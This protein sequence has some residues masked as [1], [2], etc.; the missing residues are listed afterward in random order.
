MNI[1]M[2]K[3]IEEQLKSIG[4]EQNEARAEA[5]WIAAF[6]SDADKAAE[7]VRR[8]SSREPLQYIFGE[9][10][11]RFLTL[12]VTPETLIPRPETEE[13]VDIVLKTVK[14]N[15]RML[16]LG[17]GSGAIILASLHERKDL[18]GIGADI[19]Q[20]AL[21][22]AEENRSKYNITRA[23]FRQSDLFSAL[24]GEKFDLIAANLPYVSEAEWR[25]L[26]PEVR[27]FEP[28]TALTAGHDG[29]ELMEKTLEQAGNF[30]N[31]GGTV[32]FELSP[33]QAPV[34]AEYAEK[35]GCKSTILRDMTDRDR[36]VSAVFPE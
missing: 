6:T 4:I 34:I 31:P 24:S 16:D 10:D 35:L 20:G 29:L 12:K 11:F 3:S 18:S 22:V 7:I 27:D 36:F 15:G 14:R 13:L 26:E 32:I 28:I 17:C 21:K 5:R 30:L 23:V 33:H 19:S 25:E 2:Q 9:A 8:R 1:Q